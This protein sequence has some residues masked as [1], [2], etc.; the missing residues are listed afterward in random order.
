MRVNSYSA[1]GVIEQKGMVNSGVG[2]T[3]DKN[4]RTEVGCRSIVPITY[5]ITFKCLAPA[6][7][8]TGT[9]GDIVPLRAR[10]WCFLGPLRTRAGSAV[11]RVQEPV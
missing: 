5:P 8:S 6:I 4:L 7:Y 1:V 2:S 3:K 9:T 10:R 11:Y